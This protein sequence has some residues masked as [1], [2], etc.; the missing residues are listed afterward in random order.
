VRYPGRQSRTLCCRRQESSSEWVR[1]HTHPRLSLSDWS[2]LGC[3]ALALNLVRTW[4]FE[5]P[6]IE[7]SQP[8]VPNGRAQSPVR[9]RS[10][11][12]A[13][14]QRQ[15]SVFIDMDVPSAAPTRPVSPTLDGD[16]PKE[17]EGADTP[18]SSARKTGIGN[19]MKTAKQTAQV[20]EFDMDSFG[21]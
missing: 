21:F 7:P 19:L 5:R 15:P 3:H 1:A 18:N 14:M 4:F 2:R 10:E 6:S 8:L 12:G 9:H 20:P 11:M 16:L 17:V 13:I